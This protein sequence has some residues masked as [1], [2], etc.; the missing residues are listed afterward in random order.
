MGLLSQRGVW[1]GGFSLKDPALAE[2]FGSGTRTLAGPLVNELTAFACAAFW[3]GVQ[4]ISSDVAKLPLHLMKRRQNGGSDHFTDSRSYKLMKYSPNPEMR[5]MVFRRTIT[6]HA[7]VYGNGYAEIVRNPL[8]QP[9]A[10][11][12]LHPKRVQPFYESPEKG[13]KRL[14]YRI[15]GEQVLDPTDMLHIQGLGDDGVAGFNVVGI[16]REA[17]GLSLASQQF[18]AAFFGNG[19]RFGGVLSTDLDLDEEQEQGIRTQIEALHAK[20]DKAFRLLILGGGFKF[21]SSGVNPNEAQMKEIRDQQVTEIARFLNMPLHKLKL[22]TPGAVSYASVE[23]SDLDYYKGCLLNWIQLWEEELNAKLV[24]PLEVGRQYFK[25]NVNG[26]LRAD[27]KTRQDGLA[28]MHDRGVINADDWLELEDMNPQ[29]DG[30]GQMYLVQGAMVPKDKVSAMADA[31]IAK[32][33]PP[34]APDDQ[35]VQDLDAK[36]ARAEAIAEEARTAYHQE[37]DLRVAAEA[38]AGATQE[39]VSVRRAAEGQA[40]ARA[41]TAEILATDL[42]LEAESQAARCAAAEAARVQADED[43]AAARAAVTASEDAAAAARLA[44]EQADGARGQMVDEAAAALA[45]AE[46]AEARA[47]DAERLVA[48]A[49]AATDATVAARLEALTAELEAAQAAVVVARQAVA[50]ATSQAAADREAHTAAT[51]RA[52]TLCRE[53]EAL[54]RHQRDHLAGVLAAHRALIVDVAQRL[55]ERE[56]DR[57]KSRQQSAEKLR[58]WIE[59]FY[60][61]FEGT[62]EEA[63]LPAVRVHVAWKQSGEDPRQVARDL[64]HAHVEAST[65]HLRQMLAAETSDLQVALARLLTRWEQDRPGQIADGLLQDEIAHLA[66]LEQA[67]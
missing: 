46:A 33:T 10:L 32:D 4:Q 13:Q 37:H 26:F 31:R 44:A 2:L 15:D 54:K 35:L 7:L 67:S 36:A 29:P 11:W 17:L 61:T 51:A 50:D 3:D 25:H 23:M 55:V 24:A 52:D 48:E 1:S 41:T 8:R 47:M 12:L 20:A 63:I 45:L 34:P 40:L 6:S 16:A 53:A 57:A 22:A 14:R 49:T 66:A 42:R 21:E 18:A 27:F 62:F 9:T 59:T 30:Q 38:T 39:E 58:G 19:T 56:V 60:V 64:A 43:A 65:A 5:S 28:I